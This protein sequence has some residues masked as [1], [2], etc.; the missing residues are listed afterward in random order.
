MTIIVKMVVEP[1][2]TD[3]ELV[4]LMLLL[5][6]DIRVRNEGEDSSSKFG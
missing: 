2:K 1:R 5:G 6:S 3:S 4:S